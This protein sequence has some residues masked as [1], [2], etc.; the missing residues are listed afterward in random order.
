VEA[1]VQQAPAEVAV[2]FGDER[3]TYHELNCRANQLA[4]HLRE[5]GAAPEAL[6]AICTERSLDTVVG[7]LAVLKAGA[8]Y[9]PLDPDFPPERLKAMLDD[10]RPCLVLT[11]DRLVSRLPQPNAPVVCLDTERQ[12]FATASDGNPNNLTQPDNLAYVLYTS[13]STGKPK[14]VAMSHRALVNLLLWQAESED[15]GTPART[16]QFA[17]FCFDV[18][19]QEM[20]TTWISGGTLVL[21][22][23]S[24]RRDPVRLAKLLAREGVRRAFLPPVML[25]H[26]AEAATATA[27]F[28]AQLR[29]V[30]AAGE[31][32]QVTPE[33]VRLASRQDGFVL[34]NHYGPTESHVVTAQRLMGRADDWP[35][36]PPIG[37]PIANVRIYLVDEAGREVPRGDVGELWIGG[38]CLARGYLGRPE[39]TAEKFVPDPFSSQPGSRLYRTGDLARYLG[40]GS[41]EYVGR[42]DHQVKIRGFRIELG[43]IEVVLSSHPEV[44]ESVVVAWEI[45]PGDKRLAAYFVPRNGQTI[46]GG[47]LRTWLRDRLPEYMVPSIFVPLGALP[48]NANGKVD[49]RALQVPGDQAPDRGDLLVPPRNLVEKRLVGLWEEILKIRP[50]GV[51][52]NVFQIGANS[53][54]VM[55]LQLRLESEFE[56]RLPAGP[57]AQAPTV[58]ALAELLRYGRT[59]SGSCLVPIQRQGERPPFYCV[60]G[61]AGTVLT[62]YNLA[63]HLGPGRPFYGLRMKG[64]YGKE[65]P[66]ERIEEMA[67]EYLQEIKRVQPQGPYYLGGYCFGGLVA[68]EIAQQLRR[69]GEKVAALLVINGLSPSASRPRSVEAVR[70]DPPVAAGRAWSPHFVV[71]KFIGVLR[72]AWRGSRRRWRRMAR[73]LGTSVAY[74]L[75]LRLGLPV[76]DTLRTRYFAR[77]MAIAEARYVPVVYPGK[78]ALIRGEGF[79]SDPFLGWKP[80]VAG[81]LQV[82]AVPGDHENERQVWTEPH[83]QVMAAKL[84]EYLEEVEANVGGQTQ[85]IDGTEV[86]RGEIAGQERAPTSRR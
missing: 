79:G 43:E 83:I 74:R 3:L 82:L 78:M 67:A 22:P 81:D 18:S 61:G 53:L 26:L 31:Q 44:S 46:P 36:M 5:R 63:K 4:H 35:A 34:H 13:G 9:M 42:A 45:L 12:A 32:L 75:R 23:E 38:V 51:K 29:E 55:R 41:L 20:F 66:P 57:L 86:R 16:L 73:Y 48:L 33:V 30:I 21:A 19:F 37:T 64:R 1:Q 71:R 58:E 80:L 56:G 15:L 7:V 69:R 72:R 70:R 77:V 11:Q 65:L 60:H 84:R 39:L 85:A 40:D 27:A 8:A 68:F 2:V 25:K 6:V 54:A 49:R 62:Y 17:S 47:E 28:P 50:I 10:A 14:G 76:S 24:V 59:E 52:D